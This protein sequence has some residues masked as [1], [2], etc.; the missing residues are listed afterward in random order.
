MSSP[1]LGE[2]RWV[3]YPFAP[4]GWAFCN[5]QLMSIQQNT[6]LFSLLGTTFG[7]NGTTTFALPNMQG[8]VPIHSGSSPYPLGSTGGEEGHT[9]ITSE[10]P[11]HAHA[12]LCVNATGNSAVPANSLWAISAKNDTAYSG[13]GNAQMIAGSIT[14]TGGGQAH[15]NR[16]PYLVLSLT[17]ALVGI[18][19]SRN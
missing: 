15:E 1:F 14:P 8:R 4:K 7:G 12:G 10:I 17:I 6:A 16:Q 5:G 3:A 11:A 18:F 2:M 9:L 13:T 19:P